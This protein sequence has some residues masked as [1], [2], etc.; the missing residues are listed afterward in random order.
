MEDEA[1]TPYILSYADRICY[2]DGRSYEYDRTIRDFTLVDKAQSKTREEQFKNYRDSVMFYIEH[3]N[4]KRIG[5]L[6]K[7]AHKRLTEKA[8]VFAYAEYGEL[9]N[10]I[11]KIKYNL[12]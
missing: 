6:K 7:L 9:W 12:N 5:M 8:K 10:Q 2:I 3:G 4:T 1:W 11:E